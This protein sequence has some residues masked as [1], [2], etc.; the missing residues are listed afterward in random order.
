[1]GIMQD[2]RLQKE[3][4]FKTCTE[5][6]INRNVAKRRR[7]LVPSKRS[8]IRER[9]LAEHT[10]TSW[11]SVFSAVFRA[12]SSLTLVGGESLEP[13]WQGIQTF[14]HVDGVHHTAQLELNAAVNRKTVE[15]LQGRSDEVS[16][17]E[18]HY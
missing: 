3:M 5:L 6:F 2:C 12:Q 13:G 14:T 10:T 4:N 1:M 9:T 7:K 15:L 8:C 18:V 11:Q 16:R 17:S